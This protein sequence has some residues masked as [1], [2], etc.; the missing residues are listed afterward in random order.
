MKTLKFLRNYTNYSDFPSLEL[1]EK[2]IPTD[3]PLQDI[4]EKDLSDKIGQVYEDSK[5][6]GLSKDNTEKILIIITKSVCFKTLVS[7]E[8]M[9]FYIPD[10]IKELKT[11][12]TFKNTETFSSAFFSLLKNI[13]SEIETLDL[14]IEN[15]KY[16]AALKNYATIYRFLLS[17]G[18]T[19]DM[20]NEEKSNFL[21]KLFCITDS[22]SLGE[23]NSR[24]QNQK[25]PNMH[26]INITENRDIPIYSFICSIISKYFNDLMFYIFQT[27]KYFYRPINDEF[28]LYYLNGIIILAYRYDDSV[29]I[30]LHV[31]NNYIGMQN[32]R[33]WA[34]IL[35]DKKLIDSLLYGINLKYPDILNEKPDLIC[36]EEFLDEAFM[37]YLKNELSEEDAK[38]LGIQLG[39]F[40]PSKERKNILVLKDGSIIKNPR[41][42][43]NIKVKD[44]S[45]YETLTKILSLSGEEREKYIA[46]I[47]A[48]DKGIFKKEYIKSK[49]NY[50]PEKKNE[51]AYID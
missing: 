30:T 4:Q 45:S 23:H 49:S 37:Q 8:E 46:K 19:D 29:N 17:E 48:T 40:I 32:F 20:K 43:E 12:E 39:V 5:K 26:Y 13:F 9:T 6:L 50:H 14:N 27:H 11:N 47:I 31:I 2:I 7:N 35:N 25:Y 15:Q 38:R 34:N 1:I 21:K 10:I 24:M 36:P 33:Y 3:L 51:K 28:S 16:F 22:S 42:P 44:Q 41:I 18:I